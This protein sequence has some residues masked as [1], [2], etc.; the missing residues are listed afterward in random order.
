MNFVKNLTDLLRSPRIRNRFKCKNEEIYRGRT[1]E[2]FKP[3]RNRSDTLYPK[4]MLHKPQE[5]TKFNGKNLQNLKKRTTISLKLQ[6]HILCTPLL[7]Q[8]EL[9]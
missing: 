4:R 8:I 2:F 6:N 1:K 7:K 3:Q 5:N 9:I